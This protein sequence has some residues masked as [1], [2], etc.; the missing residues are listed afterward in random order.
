MKVLFANAAGALKEQ[1][2]ANMATPLE[3]GDIV[4]LEDG[5]FKVADR[6]FKRSQGE[7]VI[8]LILTNTGKLNPVMGL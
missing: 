5:A 4:E 1:V 6:F 3:V 8:T 7:W 2:P